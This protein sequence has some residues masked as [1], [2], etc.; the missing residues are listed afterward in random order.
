VFALS[1]TASIPT[2]Q[3][4][5]LATPTSV[6]APKEPDEFPA[7]VTGTESR[8]SS[9]AVSGA[10][11]G[12]S[13][14]S[15]SKDAS[16]KSDQTVTSPS[17]STF[18]ASRQSRRLPSPPSST[19][20]S[21][22]QPSVPLVKSAT[23]KK[24]D[25]ESVHAVSPE[26]GVVD[27]EAGKASLT[28]LEKVFTKFGLPERGEKYESRT[29]VPGGYR[30][31]W[32][33]TLTIGSIEK[34]LATFALL[35]FVP[36]ILFYFIGAFDDVSQNQEINAQ[37]SD[38]SRSEPSLQTA[39]AEGD[40]SATQGQPADRSIKLRVQGSTFQNAPADSGASNP[41]TFATMRPAPAD[42]QN[43][44]RPEAKRS[45]EKAEEKKVTADDL[46]TD[47]KKVTVDDLINDN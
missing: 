37:E 35:V 14:A 26:T 9:E 30:R 17:E 11:S 16:A 1:D 15:I 34:Y 28:E 20:A 22:L 13:E 47:K 2:V 38:A 21:D 23:R 29:T 45:R 10:V 3:E 24:K 32:G 8:E 5:D 18:A 6:V 31:G 42:R 33:R 36:S 12:E 7:P 19:P 44:D 46:I 4:S 41:A 27:D 39:V 43:S 40:P 25:E